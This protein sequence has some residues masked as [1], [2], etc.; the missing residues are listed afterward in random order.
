MKGDFS[1]STFDPQKH[2]RGVRMQQG[3]VQL[4]ADWNENLDILLRRIE[5]ETI[6]VIGDCGV[7][8][9]DAGFGV[10]TDFN[11]L[12]QAEQDWLTA[13]G[14]N[15]LGAGDFY[16]TQGRAYVDGLQVENDH[17][18]P[19]SQQP[20]VLPAGQGLINSDGAYWLYLD[21]WE[22][23]LTVIEDPAIREVALGGPDTATRT[24]VIWQARLAQAND[25]ATCA[26]EFSPG[27]SPSTGRLSAR[28]QPA[29]QPDDPCAVPPGAGYKRLENQ[30]YRVEIHR[31]SD[32]ASG[33][34]FKWSRDN[35]SVAAAIAEFN[36]DGADTKIRTTSLGRDDMLGLHQNDWVEVLDDATE[37]AGQPGTLVQIT[38]I[39]P[40]NILSL[41]GSITGYDLNGH[42]KV[43]RWD[44]VGEASLPNDYAALEDGVEVKFDLT[45]TY[46]TGDYWLIP[47]R[48]VPGQYGDIEWPQENSN[49]AALLPF[50]IA[51]HYCK[52]AVL[53]FSSDVFTDVDDCRKKFPPLTELP[54]GGSC[55][56]SVSVGTGGD[57]P[58]L[59]SA[60]N[61]RP[62]TADAWHICL[63]AGEYKL[64][65]PV[66]ADQ[67]Q[68]L[69]ISGCD[70]QSRVFGPQ[71]KPAFVFKQGQSIQLD[72]LWVESSAPDGALIFN[73]TISAVVS[74][75][76]L[77]NKVVAD[78]P[79]IDPLPNSDKKK[80]GNAGPLIIVN[81]GQGTQIDENDL[82]G[83]PAVMA[84]GTGLAVR[85]N[86]IWGG[87]LQICLPSSDVQIEDNTILMGPGP[88]ICLGG[89]LLASD[90]VELKETEPTPET[91]P[92]QP[93]PKNIYSLA[94]IRLVTIHS[95]KIA[96][97][98]GSG[99]ITAT[100]LGKSEKV[101]DVQSLTVSENQ[102]LECC[103]EPDIS[104][105]SKTRVG[106]G[107]A[108][109][110]V[111]GAQI[112]DN[113]IVGNGRNKRP[114][115]GIFLLEGSDINIEGN[116]I[117]DN[118]VKENKAEPKYYQAG[119]A[120][121]F[122]SGNPLGTKTA[123]SGQVGRPAVRIQDNEVVC[124]A[125]Q[126]L[127][128]TA[129]GGVLVDGNILVSHEKLAQPNHPL[130]FGEKGAC[131]SVLNL[132][133]PL[134][135]PE[136]GVLMQMMASG[137]AQ[138]HLEDYKSADSAFAHFP[139]GRV[140][141][142]NNQV[143]FRSEREEDVKSLGKMNDQWSKQVWE[144]IVF[145][146]LFISLDDVSLSGNQ[147]QAYVPAYI[148]KGLEADKENWLAYGLKFM[149][150][151]C[152][153]TTLRATGNGFSEPLFSNIVSY[154]SNATALNVTTSNEATHGFWTLAPKHSEANNLSLIA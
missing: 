52:L 137:P 84:S 47:A 125:G 46:R 122:V 67:A 45:G 58:D 121:Q 66:T 89:E 17:S 69:V 14:F 90:F 1:R 131:V 104:L 8:V 76:K 97:L 37:L 72:H 130:N 44:S 109:V 142:H 49:P 141:F 74:N 108:L 20:F 54:T 16:L 128:I 64:L 70:G 53:T 81:N 102:I 114:A 50:G 146:A 139:D 132:G 12:P 77:S 63:L 100:T 11:S 123:S 116:L 150:V 153:A 143:T 120:I 135:L 136:F 92:A 15:S 38:K 21:V 118:G 18:L 43:R 65:D 25:G 133:L 140:L 32:I 5:S 112:R 82:L 138:F 107:I 73:E 30:L 51:H 101:S 55:C 80:L 23:H 86:R 3:R 110:G 7:P 129:V 68:G 40:D 75:C 60:L 9:H 103:Q 42:P 134:W 28:T 96:R 41:S 105:S 4:D 24:Q 93:E 10:V 61:A 78:N 33:P 35:G 59:Q 127:T 48:T 111:F 83:L 29:D 91:D 148:L 115:C 99:I 57:Y 126:A 2:Y 106:G 6:D 149:Q 85:R 71:G 26:D 98:A 62:V 119:I 19:F 117:T 39:D 87:G 151:G 13:Q 95:N 145:S 154:L 79:L 36:V 94:R 88:G 31:G 34:T 144:E 22:R 152:V 147:F 124:P 56:C 27:P 113:V